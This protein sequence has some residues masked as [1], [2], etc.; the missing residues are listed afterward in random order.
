MKESR[1]IP[2]MYVPVAIDSSKEKLMPLNDVPKWY[3]KLDGRKMALATVYRWR[4]IGCAGVRLAVCYV[5]GK[6]FTSEEALHRFDAAV[7]AAKQAPS[8]PMPAT[9]KHVAKAHA[10]AKKRLARA[11]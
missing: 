6:P 9:A 5:G 3:G 7:T 11:K 8:V 2:P 4:N 1:F 10:E